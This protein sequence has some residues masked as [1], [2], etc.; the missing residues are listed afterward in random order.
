MR[1]TAPRCDDVNKE[2]E[3]TVTCCCNLLCF[4]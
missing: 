4:D 3:T 2:K 1:A